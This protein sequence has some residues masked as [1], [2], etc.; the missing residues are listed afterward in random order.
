MNEDASLQNCM[1]VGALYLW[2]LLSMVLCNWCLLWSDYSWNKRQPCYLRTW[3]F[4]RTRTLLEKSTRNNRQLQ[5]HKRYSGLVMDISENASKLEYPICNSLYQLWAFKK[6]NMLYLCKYDT[7][8]QIGCFIPSDN[9]LQ[10]FKQPNPYNC[11]KQRWSKMDSCECRSPDNVA[12]LLISIRD[13]LFRK[14]GSY[15]SPVW[16]V[17]WKVFSYILGGHTVRPQKIKYRRTLWV[18]G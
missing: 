5:Y 3:P 12:N 15:I 17:S 10:R 9:Q 6:W 11:G 13:T 14:L 4:W 2:N 7:V 8:W 1:V 16:L 18:K